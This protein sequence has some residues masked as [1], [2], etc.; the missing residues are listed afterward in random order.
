MKTLVFG[1]GLLGSRYLGRKDTVVLSRADCDITSWFDVRGALEHYDPTIVINC[2][3]VV[4]RSGLRAYQMM[5]T[6]ALGPKI[7]RAECDRLNAKLV[8]ISTDCV[9]D[10]RSIIP[11]VETDMP[12]AD[13]DYGVSKFLGEQTEYPHL[14]IRTSFVGL[15]DPKGRGLLNWAAQAEE[16]TG[17]DHVFWNGTTNKELVDVLDNL[18]RHDYS[19]LYHIYSS[20]IVTKFQLLVTANEIFGWG[21][22]IKRWSDYNTVEDRTRYMVLDSLNPEVGQIDKPIYDQLKELV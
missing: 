18:I 5:R 11:Y 8:Q 6:N 20:Q 1:D 14:T 10:G 17:Y 2:A 3:G 12:N 9:F 19:G 15:P 16:I 7:L 13:D 22:T 21:K 4:N